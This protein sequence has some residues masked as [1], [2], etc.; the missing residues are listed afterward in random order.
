[1]RRGSRFQ[2]LKSAVEGL[3]PYQANLRV[4]LGASLGQPPRMSVSPSPLRRR[5]LKGSGALLAGTVLVPLAPARAWAEA[6]GGSTRV[7]RLH[8]VHTAESGV[9]PFFQAGSRA[10]EVLAR[11]QHFFRDFRTGH[12]HP[13]DTGL[14]D[15]LHE[16]AVTLDRDPEFEVICGYRSPKTNEYLRGRSASSGVAQ[17]SLHLEGLAVDV[18][19]VGVSVERLHTAGL[20]LQRGGAGLYTASQFVHFDTGR[21]RHWGS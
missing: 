21:V 9:F 2:V 5:F 17:R 10:P 20:S 18:R 14:F 4:A 15:L 3:V 12:E 6:H 13:L 19:M 8:N 1:M 16:V 11:L 7:L